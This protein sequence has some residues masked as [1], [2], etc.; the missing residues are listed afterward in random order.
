MRILH[1]HPSL[2]SFTTVKPRKLLEEEE[3]RASFKGPCDPKTQCR[4]RNSDVTTRELEF[5]TFDN[6]DIPPYESFRLQENQSDL[7]YG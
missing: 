4:T 1:L 3:A 6:T 2:L 5:L 7:I